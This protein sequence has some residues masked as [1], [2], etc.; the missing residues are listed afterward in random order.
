ML[1]ECLS[2]NFWS[3]SD[4]MYQ[5]PQAP[6]HVQPEDQSE[7]ELVDYLDDGDQ[8]IQESSNNNNPVNFR[9]DRTLPETGA[10]LSGIR[11]M[12]STRL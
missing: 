9:L 6:T 3:N 5:P 7:F 10:H 11:I 8:L 12:F 2:R 1:K 4:C